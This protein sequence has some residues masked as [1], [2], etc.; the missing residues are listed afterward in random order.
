[1]THPVPG[2]RRRIDR[3]LAEGFLDGIEHISIDE[4]R[5]RRR[6]A[7]Q[8]D[9]DLSYVRRLLHGRLDIIRAE[10]ARRERPNGAD[11]Q[12]GTGRDVLDHLSGILAG[13]DPSPRG[14]GRFL[15]V[16]PSAVEMRRRDVEQAIADVGISDVRAR[17]KDELAAALSRL[18]RFEHMVSNNRARVH[19]VMDRLTGEIARRYKEGSATV[20]DLLAGR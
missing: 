17:S 11:A 13:P 5:L 20:D 14:S 2:G 16:E 8:E 6:E 18:D 9:A 3:V 12:A 7:E 10:I 1:M 19:K 4:L 15:T